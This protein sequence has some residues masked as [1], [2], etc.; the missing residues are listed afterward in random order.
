MK[1]RFFKELLVKW[2]KTLDNLLKFAEIM[3]VRDE[4]HIIHSCY[5]ADWEKY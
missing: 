5:A 2:A 4:T 1:Y 3:D